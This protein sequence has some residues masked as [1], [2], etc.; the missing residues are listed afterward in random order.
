MPENDHRSIGRCIRR[1]LGR[2]AER[3]RL[4]RRKSVG[5]RKE[6][7]DLPCIHVSS[8]ARGQGIGK[9]LFLIAAEWAK[10]RG[11]GK[12]YISAHSSVESQ[13]VYRAMGCLEAAEYDAMHAEK[14]P[15]DCQMEYDLSRIQ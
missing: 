5:S 3:I 13:A 8:D 12:L 4:G 1:V 10:T 9:R 15:I 2:K 14:E 11:A 6:Y 7:L